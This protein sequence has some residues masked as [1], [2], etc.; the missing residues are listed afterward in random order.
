MMVL[1]PLRETRKAGGVL[2]GKF[3]STIRLLRAA[4]DDAAEVPFGVLKTRRM[5]SSQTPTMRVSL[6][7]TRDS[8][9]APHP[10]AAV[11]TSAAESCS[12]N[13][14]MRHGSRR[15]SVCACNQ[16]T[17]PTCS[18]FQ[19]CSFIAVVQRRGGDYIIRIKPFP[20]GLGEAKTQGKSSLAGT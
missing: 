14:I 19:H 12:V 1:L 13:I 8:R 20:I 15:N 9:D 10:A 11:A 17:S 4:S 6:M 7:S 3:G 18:P 5:P 16:R 2:R